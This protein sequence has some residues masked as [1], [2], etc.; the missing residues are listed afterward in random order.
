MV[1]VKVPEKNPMLPKKKKS[2]ATFTIYSSSP[3]LPNNM[4]K[5]NAL[6]RRVVV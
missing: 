3:N 5:P 1:V 6:L 4:K 2:N